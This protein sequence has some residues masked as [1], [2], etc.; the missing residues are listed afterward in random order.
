MCEGVSVDFYSRLLNRSGVVTTTE[1]EIEN[2]AK[3]HTKR[4]ANFCNIN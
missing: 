4:L 3:I 1:S 2:V